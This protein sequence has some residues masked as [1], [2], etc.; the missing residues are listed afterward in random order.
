MELFKKYGIESRI[1]QNP[2]GFGM[3]IEPFTVDDTTFVDKLAAATEYGSLWMLP[4][5]EDAPKNK[6][7]KVE[8]HLLGH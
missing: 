4:E 7:I 8:C 6:S 2:Y 3:D 5:N 1:H